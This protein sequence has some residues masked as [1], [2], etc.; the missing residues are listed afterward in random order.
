MFSAE[1]S[2]VFCVELSPRCLNVENM[3][4]TI[5][6]YLIYLIFIAKMSLP[7]NVHHSNMNCMYDKRVRS[8]G[9]GFT[10]ISLCASYL[11]VSAR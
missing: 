6:Q 8:E 1:I 5:W 10:D 9:Y 4:E 7:L 2:L 3:S 11:S